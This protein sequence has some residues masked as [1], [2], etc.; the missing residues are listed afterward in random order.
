MHSFTAIIQR[1]SS[2]GEK[3]GWTYV[4]IPPDILSKLKLS[5]KKEFRVKGFMDD[6][7]IVQLAAYPIG[8]G[9]YIIAINAEL[10]KKLGKKQGAMLK[11]K[12][13]LDESERAKSKDLE[14]C[15]QEDTS[16]STFFESLNRSHQNYF[17][18]YVLTA[19]TL[20]TKT[21]RLVNIINAMHRKQNFGEMIRG[22][23]EKKS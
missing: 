16:A 21:A 22:L 9:N 17:H 10:R 18:T 20:P 8:E 19:K 14:A 4:D 7:A 3:T 6:I 2:K 1:F 12:I 11:L 13:K 23:K 5:S 15:L